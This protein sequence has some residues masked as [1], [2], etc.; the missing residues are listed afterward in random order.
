[1][2]II[3]AI[4]IPSLLRNDNGVPAQLEDIEAVC[5]YLQQRAIA[6]NRNQEL[7]IDVTAH[8]YS[9]AIG[10]KRQT[11]PLH[12][13]ILFGFSG[14]VLGPPA[15]PEGPITTA[16]TFPKRDKLHVMTFYPTGI[17]SAGTIYFIDKQKRHLGALTSSVSQ[18]SYIRR[19]C[20]TNNKW[21]PVSA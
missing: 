3:A 12:H 13:N 7:C 10:E 19:Y 20:Y 14:S 2:V 6:S 21:T 8:T 16:C 11:F 5:S 9:Y 15:N 18:V 1:V 4:S 17:I